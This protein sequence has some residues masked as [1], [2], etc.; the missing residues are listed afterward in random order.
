MDFLVKK[1]LADF[2]I[3]IQRHQNSSDVTVTAVL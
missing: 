1:N 3:W 2:R